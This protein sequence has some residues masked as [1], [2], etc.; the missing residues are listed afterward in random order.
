MI[1]KPY[2]EDNIRIPK[3]LQGESAFVRTCRTKRVIIGS[4]IRRTLG[5]DFTTGDGLDRVSDETA[6]LGEARYLQNL[7]QLN[8]TT[9]LGYYEGDRTIDT[10]VRGRRLPTQLSTVTHK[11]AY[12]YAGLKLMQRLALEGGVSVD[13][14]QM[15]LLPRRQVNPRSG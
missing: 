2:C 14:F 1:Q 5:T 15:P 8:I 13:D 7:G 10:T 11:N 12:V 4:Y 6:H 3:R 9:G